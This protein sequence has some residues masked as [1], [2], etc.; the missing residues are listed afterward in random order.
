MVAQV[1]AI[2]SYCN[3]Q[4]REGICSMPVE[5]AEEMDTLKYHSFIPQDL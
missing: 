5:F 2:P 4:G 1:R 3:K